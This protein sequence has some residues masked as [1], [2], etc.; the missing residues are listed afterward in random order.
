MLAVMQ[1]TPE[2][3]HAHRPRGAGA[4][5]SHF[6]MDAKAEE[7]EAFYRVMLASGM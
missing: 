1:T 4:H 3:R 5:Q 6:S 2:A 7:W